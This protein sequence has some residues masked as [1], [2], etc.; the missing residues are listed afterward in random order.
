MTNT[1]FHF[2]YD[3]LNPNPVEGTTATEATEPASTITNATVEPTSTVMNTTVEP[4]EATATVPETEPKAYETTNPAYGTT[5]EPTS[6]VSA[7][8]AATTPT[9]T[10]CPTNK[11]SNP[12]KVT[13]KKKSVKAKKLKKYTQN[14]K[15]LTIRTAKGKVTVKLVKKGSNSKLFKLAKISNKGIITLKKWKKAKNGTYKLKVRITAK[16]NSAFKSKT[17]NKVVKIRIE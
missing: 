15:A 1:A 8:A 14:V 7:T 2:N 13:A 11:A 9:K 10:L 12:I 5:T 16:G 4:T 3:P 6:T 17:I